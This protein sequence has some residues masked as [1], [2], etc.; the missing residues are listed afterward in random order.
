GY[1]IGPQDRVLQKTP[2]SFD[3]SVWEFFVPLIAGGSLVV[4]APGGH[5]DP[6]YLERII[7]ERGITIAHFVPSMLQ[8]FLNSRTGDSNARIKKLICSGE[9]LGAGVARESL[10]TFAD[11]VLNLYGPTEAAVEVTYW[12]C[13]ATELEKNR[14]AIGR[15]VA[16]TTVYAVDE[17]MY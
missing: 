11:E 3:V 7:E 15:P 1:K 9:A 6:A 17:E 12:S 14:V 8:T 5:K 4:A 16:N 2:F 13:A 10:A